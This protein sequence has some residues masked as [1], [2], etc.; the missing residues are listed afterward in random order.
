MAKGGPG[1]TTIKGAEANNTVNNS[2]GTAGR[3]MPQR[4]IA[5]PENP[6][7]PISMRKALARKPMTGG[8]KDFPGRVQ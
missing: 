4:P 5:G 1:N 3:S 6:G 7:P 2:G 8:G